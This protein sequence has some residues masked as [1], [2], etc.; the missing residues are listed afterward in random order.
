MYDYFYKYNLVY[1]LN[2]A[3]R[4][5]SKFL[6]ISMVLF[7][8]FLFTSCKDTSG[9]KDEDADNFCNTCDENDI[10]SCTYTCKIS[11]WH[12]KATSDTLLKYGSTKL[13]YYMRDESQVDVIFGESYSATY[14]PS[15]PHCAQENTV[16]FTKKLEKNMNNEI[17]P[18][19]S[20]FTIKDENNR[21]IWFSDITLN[22]GCRRIP[23][24]FP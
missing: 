20:H 6:F 9:C 18:I 2:F 8:F 15:E 24:T 13:K 14:W 17:I 19:Q 5:L 11:F 22:K 7:G 21:V 1:L 23:L 10:P 4:N 12:G 3:M 16:T